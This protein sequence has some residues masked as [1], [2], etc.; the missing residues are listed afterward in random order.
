M[1][2]SEQS[3]TRLLSISDLGDSQVAVVEKTP[4]GALAVGIS[5]GKPFAVSNRCRHLF[6]S[7]GRGQVTDD[8]CLQCPWHAA[9]YDVGT[10]KMV[11]GPQG[12][13]KPLAG[14]VKATAGARSL[15]TFPVELRD[16]A[17]WLTG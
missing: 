2:T 11:R 8:G 9:L 6:A 1:S 15:K 17:I 13:F 16:G 14:A 10:G 4:H 12:A 7:L 3:A 5:A